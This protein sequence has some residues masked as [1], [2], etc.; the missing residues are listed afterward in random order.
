MISRKPDSGSVNIETDTG[1]LSAVEPYEIP[2]I[3][4]SPIVFSHG[5]FSWN[6]D[7]LETG[8]NSTITITL[9]ESLP[10]NSQY[11]KIINGSWIDVTSLLGSNDGDDTITITLTDGGIGDADGIA[12]GRIV[13]P[14]GPA[15]PNDPPT[16][17]LLGNHT[18]TVELGDAYIDAGAT[19][20]DVQDGNLTDS[21]VTQNPVDTRTVGNYT[22][23]YDVNDSFG[24]PS[25][26]IFRIIMVQDTIIPIVT[27]PS[28]FTAE[29]TNL[30]TPLNTTNYGV[31]TATDLSRVIITSNTPDSFGIGDTMV[32]WSAM[33]ISNNTST[34]NQTISIVD[35]T[36]PVITPPNDITFEATN[37]LTPLTTSNYGT[38]TDIFGT[39]ITNNAASSF[40]IGDHAITWSV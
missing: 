9:P 18:I 26:T 30:L 8:Q 36:Q 33:D 19:A 32:T 3:P 6:V 39:I 34:A 12:N 16:I 25:D 10:T 24:I 1:R 29:A 21:I 17:T 5:L 35:T 20:F 40:A 15:I 22:V 7:G 13:D 14:G 11:W 38:A 4:R 28:D 23:S 37:L 31:A 27:A 2:D